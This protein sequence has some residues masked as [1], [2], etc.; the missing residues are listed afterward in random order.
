[1]HPV[2]VQIGRT[3]PDASDPLGLSAAPIQED[4]RF[5]PKKSFSEASTGSRMNENLIKGKEYVGLQRSGLLEIERILLLFSRNNLKRLDLANRLQNKKAGVNPM[6]LHSLDEISKREYYNFRLFGD[7]SESPLRIHLRNRGREF[8]HAIPIVPLLRDPSFLGIIYSG[9]ANCP[10]TTDMINDCIRSI[11]QFT[12]EVEN[13][14]AE[15]ECLH[16]SIQ[17]GQRIQKLLKEPKASH[18][19]DDS[20][21]SVPRSSGLQLIRSWM[22]SFRINQLIPKQT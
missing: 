14:K 21:N 3:V 19:V 18:S 11:L 16:K 4:T 17:S 2:P 7:G 13:E 9:R 5:A 1:M 8:T 15:M 20:V 12:L 10:P 22:K 6:F